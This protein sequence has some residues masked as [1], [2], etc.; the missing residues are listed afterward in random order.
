MASTVQ[1]LVAASGAS[2]AGTSASAAAAASSVQAGSA[3]DYLLTNP[4][5]LGS[6][7]A[8]FGTA[9]TGYFTYRG[10]SRTLALTAERIKTDIRLAEG[11]RSDDLANARSEREHAL[12]KSRR[13]T[14]TTLRKELY[15]DIVSKYHS[16]IRVVAS[17]SGQ[18]FDEEKWGAAV[19]GLL[20]AVSKTP[21]ISEVQTSLVCS[22]ANS[23]LQELFMELLQL[24]M[25]C[26]ASMA[27][28]KFH[29]SNVN[30]FSELLGALTKELDGNLT[31][32]R[33]L[34]N[35]SRAE[36]AQASIAAALKEQAEASKMLRAHQIAYSRALMA[37]I[38]AAQPHIFRFLELARA[39][40]GNSEDAAALYAKAV[41]TAQR[42][43]AASE[44]LW[45]ALEAGLGQA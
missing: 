30:Y 21:L 26:Q 2:H 27:S 6:F 45:N 25:P 16:A 7:I 37:G 32:E 34:D 24:V 42:A 20:E 10:V 1:T 39:E 35:Y 29:T 18:T 31:T 14:L 28:V 15:L 17:M 19:T 9:L 3:W 41:E 23:I 36:R 38:E 13:E 5:L 43:K 44:R 22:E 12:E 40:L 11:K 8:L 4:T 33:A